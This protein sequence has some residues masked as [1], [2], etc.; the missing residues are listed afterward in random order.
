MIA[1]E[2]SPIILCRIGKA[3]FGAVSQVLPNT[4][5]STGAASHSCTS[6]QSSTDRK[7]ASSTDG[8][9]LVGT[10]NRYGSGYL[11]NSPFCANRT[12]VLFVAV[13]KGRER[14]KSETPNTRKGFS[15]PLANR[16]NPSFAPV[17]KTD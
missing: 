11:V 12:A 1:S 6:K 3:S 2:R 7:S 16:R 17:L 15:G 8:R 10:Q 13:S 4:A 9:A 5:G 14:D